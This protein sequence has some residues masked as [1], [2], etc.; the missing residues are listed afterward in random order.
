L[1]AYAYFSS[2]FYSFFTLAKVLTIKVFVWT[3]FSNIQ[4]AISFYQ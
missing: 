4:G 2:L 3:Y 1:I